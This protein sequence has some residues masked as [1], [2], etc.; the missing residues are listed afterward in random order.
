MAEQYRLKQRSLPANGERPLTAGEYEL[1]VLV[2]SGAGQL[3]WE[4]NHAA[5]EPDTIALLRPGAQ[6]AIHAGARGIELWQL[7]LHP[8]LLRE[9]SCP[10]CDLETCF[11]VVPF[12]CAAVRLNA[13]NATLLRR[14]YSLLQAEQDD[15]KALAGGVYRRGLLELLVVGV[16]RCCVAEERKTALVGRKRLVVDEVFAYIN[17]HLAEPL[18]LKDLAAH[19]YVSP[20]HLARQFKQRTGQ[21]LHQ[22]IVKARLGRCRELL[23]NGVPLAAIWMQCGFSGYS[24]MLRSFKQE[25][26]VTPA[27][28][29]RQCCQ[30][31]R[32]YPEKALPQES[33]EPKEES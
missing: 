9:L 16:L 4:N 26:G 30:R 22:Y 33:Q 25:F 17:A 7:R 19:F 24:A 2:N 5:L 28:Y 21:T 10:G 23:C 1:V 29:Y 18:L 27:E 13:Q 32:E 11:S 3:E 12:H 6:A 14:L 31:A 15:P 20:E 8:T